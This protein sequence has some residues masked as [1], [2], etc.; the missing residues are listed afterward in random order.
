MTQFN[1][2][3]CRPRDEVAAIAKAYP[4]AWARISCE[5]NWSNKYGKRTNQT[6]H[7]TTQNHTRTA[8]R[9]R[10]FGGRAH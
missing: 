7:Q 1:K 3:V 4:Q 5:R 6:Q 10:A 9:A 2:R 8:R